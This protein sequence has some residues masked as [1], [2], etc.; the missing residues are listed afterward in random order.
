[1]KIITNPKEIEATSF[2]IID[3][4]LFDFNFP[5][6]KREIV[7]RV[8]HTTVD[9]NYAKELLFHQDATKNAIF[10]IQKGCN[11]IVDSNMAEAG[12]NKTIVKSF[13]LKVLC[14]MNDKNIVSQ[15]KKSNITRA[16]LSMRKAAKFMNGAIVAIGN[17]PTALFEV[18]DLIA[19]KNVKPALVIGMPVG[20]VGAL[21]SKKR[22]I[23]TLNIPYITNQSQKG[24]SAVAVAIVNALLILAKNSEVNNAHLRRDIAS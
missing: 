21:E 23:T 6:P 3:K 15:S 22:L 19:N 18:C 24:G 14:F 2:Q 1:M 16:I 8:I 7:R 11:I 17:A 10:A 4:F 13:K 12:I 5:T 20:F 9:L